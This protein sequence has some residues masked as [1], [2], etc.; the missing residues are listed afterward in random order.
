M[1]AFILDNGFSS[2][3]VTR[4]ATFRIFLFFATIIPFSNFVIARVYC[5]LFTCFRP[6]P[7]QPR[8]PSF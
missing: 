4:M 3:P 1:L 2:S 8:A 6:P 7:V 5:I